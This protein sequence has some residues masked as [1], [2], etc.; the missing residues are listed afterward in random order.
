MEQ[1]GK[2]NW[3][4]LAI[5]GLISILIGVFLLFFDPDQMKV[6]VFYF[7][8]F[9]LIIGAVLLIIAIRNIK[10]DKHAGMLLI[11]SI[12]T[13]IIG[14]IIVLFPDF[15]LKFFLII[16]GVWAII[17][18]IAQ[19]AILIHIKE[20]LTN[21]NILLFNALLTIV[22]GVLLFFVPSIINK[23]EPAGLFL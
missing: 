5:N 8:I 2:K 12:L 16:I 21:K 7:G 22:L 19:L 6:L 3:W 20:K 11:E 15:T 14:L 17:L 10:Q 13:L 1:K 23:T 18:G 9:I 4:F